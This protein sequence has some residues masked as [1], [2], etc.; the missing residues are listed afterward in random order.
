MPAAIVVRLPKCERF[1]P[2][3]PIAVGLPSMVWQPAQPLAVNASAPS[4]A[5]SVS[6]AAGRELRATQA[7]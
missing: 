6:G 3:L 5:M 2:I 1:G 7:W 4:F